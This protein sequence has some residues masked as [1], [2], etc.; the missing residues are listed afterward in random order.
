MYHIFRSLAKIPETHP[1]IYYD[2]VYEEIGLFLE[3]ERD[4]S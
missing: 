1:Q 4:A 2:R 3:C